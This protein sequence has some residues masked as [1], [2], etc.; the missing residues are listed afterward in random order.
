MQIAASQTSWQQDKAHPNRLAFSGVLCPLDC[1]SDDAPNGAHGKRIVVTRAAAQRALSSLHGMGI[2]MTE[3]ASGHN[4][5]AKIGHITD[6]CIEGDA[7]CISGTI[8]AADF[9]DHA[10]RIRLDQSRLGFSFEGD[11]IAVEDA[12]ANPLIITDLMFSGAALLLKEKAAFTST[13]LSVMAGREREHLPISE[14]LKMAASGQPPGF[15]MASASNPWGATPQLVRLLASRNVHS[16]GDIDR[17][18]AEQLDRVLENR[19]PSE[20]MQIREKIFAARLY[21]RNLPTVSPVRM[22]W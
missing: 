15:V 5:R 18:T 6:A 7:I 21:P 10:A 13:A 16:P 14:E 1:P 17:L 20:R 4:V 19:T 3:A 9:P 8:W 2:N 22:P 11:Q 12:N